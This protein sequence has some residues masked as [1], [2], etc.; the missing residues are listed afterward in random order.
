MNG[1]RF[2]LVYKETFRAGLVV[3]YFYLFVERESGAVGNVLTAK[4]FNINNPNG[5]IPFLIDVNGRKIMMNGF[6]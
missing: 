6:D 3:P 5:I 2:P 4:Y 1:E